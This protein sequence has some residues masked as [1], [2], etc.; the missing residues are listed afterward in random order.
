MACAAFRARGAR[1]GVR[2]AASVSGMRAIVI[3]KPG[4][5]SVLQLGEA[6]APVLGRGGAA[7]PRGG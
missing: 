1:E 7:D 6:P 5:E 2:G 3:S 4:D